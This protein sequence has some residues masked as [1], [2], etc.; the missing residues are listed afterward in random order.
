MAIFNVIPNF[1]ILEK[2]EWLTDILTT[3]NGTESRIALRE[4]PRVT[5]QA[6]FPVITQEQRR[7]LGLILEQNIK[8]IVE[9]PLWPYVSPITQVT[10]SGNSRVYFEPSR[11]P[12]V[13]GG[14]LILYNPVDGTMYED[15]IVSVETDGAVLADNV[16]EDIEGHWL[17]IMG[18]E[19]R[20]N[21]DS[22]FT[23]GPDTAEL[24]LEVQAY[25]DPAIERTDTAASLTTLN[26]L[27]IL[28][29]KFLVGAGDGLSYTRETIDGDV[30]LRADYSRHPHARYS[31]P[32]TFITQR[33]FDPT[34][35]DYW[36]KFFAT[37][38][39]GQGAFL[40]STQ[41]KDLTV[42]TTFSANASS[43][44]VVEGGKTDR[45]DYATWQYI[46]I[47]YSDGSISRHR[48]TA[49]VGAGPTTLTIS[50]NLPNDSKVAN[51]SRISYLLKTRMADTIQF[52]HGPTA[53]AI[54][55]DVTTTDQG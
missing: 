10:T 25:V 14:I 22:G 35:F 20:I 53:T 5:V 41:M 12:V 45:M 42:N 38:K 30:G 49:S 46:E 52:S 9:T 1:G 2:W 3:H 29:R 51:V 4:L 43:I 36:R 44:S 48:I 11:V 6:P 37:V 32:R 47:E 55:F 7:S 31:G 39:G 50:P 8:T 17:A 23:L 13:D 15:D 28:E 26:S 18:F 34:D 19:G 27:P 33:L 16:S 40:L 21:D 24:Q 54:S